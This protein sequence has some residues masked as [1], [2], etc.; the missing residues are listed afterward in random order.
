MTTNNSASALESTATTQTTQIG[1]TSLPQQPSHKLPDEPLVVIRPGASRV[2]PDLSGLWAYRELLYFLM[3]R[4]LKVRY[5]QTAFGVV[6]VLMQPLLTTL[7]FTVFL[8]MLV[9]V[10]S[11]GIPYPLFVF[12]GL[13]PWTFFASAV[14]SSGNSLINNAQLITKVYFPRLIIPV[15]AVGSRLL[16]FLIAFVVLAGLLAYY[17]VG[18]TWNVLML[19]VCVALAALLALGVG[20]LTASL[21]VKYRDVGVVI[22]VALQL[23]MFVSPVAYP[24]SLVPEGWR[25]LYSLNPMAGVIGGFRSA[26]FGREFDWPSIA[27]ASAL[28]LVLLAYSAYNFKRMEKS[29]ADLI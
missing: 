10:P 11:D 29:F 22:P 24:P 3:W 9:R 28:A 4:D 21:N 23:G 25:Q 5:K 17:R 7:V 6:W 20:T 12:A 16:D 13:L 26:L 1:E 19:P 8:G 18:L 14:T 27:V 2:V 15:A